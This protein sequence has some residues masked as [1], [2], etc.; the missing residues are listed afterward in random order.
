MNRKE[1]KE[2]LEI[3]HFHG[4]ID[5]DITKLD[6]LIDDYYPNK[7]ENSN[8]TRSAEYQDLWKLMEKINIIMW[9]SYMIKGREFGRTEGY[10]IMGII[11]QWAERH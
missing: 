6:N 9:E 7:S 11:E 8:L 4:Y 5:H 1:I 3:L 10:K 2:F